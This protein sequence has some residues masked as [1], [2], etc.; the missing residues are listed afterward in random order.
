MDVVVVVLKGLFTSEVKD[1]VEDD[2][3]GSSSERVSS[4]VVADK[5]GVV[6]ATKEASDVEVIHL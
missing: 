3:S 5:D 6:V 1:D 2:W 4:R